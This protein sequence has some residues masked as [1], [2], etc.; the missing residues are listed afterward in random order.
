MLCNGLQVFLCCWGRA[1]P[2]V[3]SGGQFPT[4]DYHNLIRC[5]LRV[6]MDSNLNLIREVIS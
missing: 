5:T 6:P 4:Q 2:K 3:R 1:V